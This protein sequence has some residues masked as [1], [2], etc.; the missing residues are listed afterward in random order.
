MSRTCLEVVKNNEPERVF[1]EVVNGYEEEIKKLKKRL[2]DEALTVD[3]LV[4]HQ[5]NKMN[6]N[7]RK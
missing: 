4:K 5:A 2:R 7:G 3:Q 1:I 6:G